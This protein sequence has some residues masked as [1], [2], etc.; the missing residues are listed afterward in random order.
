MIRAHLPR[1]SGTFLGSLAPLPERLCPNVEDCLGSGTL[2]LERAGIETARLDVECLLAHVLASTR[3]QVILE[4]RRRLRQVEFGRYLAL[5]LRRERREPLAYVL[6]TREFWSLPLAVS[7]GVLIPRPETETLVEASLAI[8]RRAPPQPLRRSPAPTPTPWVPGGPAPSPQPPVILDLCTGTGAVAVALARELP[9]ARIIATDISRRAIRV[10]R[11]NAERHG[12]ADRVTFL[13][14]DLWRAL[15]GHAP[16]DGVDLI[17]SNPPYIPSGTLATLM[18]EV[19]WEPRR[20]LDGG[21]DGLHFHREIIA[22]APQH[23]RPGGCLLLEIG[24]DQAAAVRGLLATTTAFEVP[25]VFQDLA[26]RDRVVVARR[27][28]S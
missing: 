25:R 5:L 26:G 18:P 19:Q 11:A 13:R 6:G 10:A 14:G 22:G 15:D 28:P 7:S 3:W 2:L 17:V 12:V 20:A 9:A 27:H 4:P 1:V 24:A 16:A 23:L 21:R 8:L